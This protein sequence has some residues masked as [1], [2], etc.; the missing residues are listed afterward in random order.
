MR[1][2]YDSDARYLI[3]RMRDEAHRFTITY[4]KL[5][6]SQRAT[7]SVLDDIPGIGPKTKRQLLNRFGSLKGIRAAEPVKLENV[8]GSAKTAILR[9]YL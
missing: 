3:Q 7:R 5:L 4:H 8:I 1:L 6:R 2:P 9:D